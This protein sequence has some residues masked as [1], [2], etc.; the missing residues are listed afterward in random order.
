MEFIE[1]ITPRSY[2]SLGWS[3][4]E[5]KVLTAKV[6]NEILDRYVKI[7]NDMVA[8]WGRRLHTAN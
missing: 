1:G 6:K 7:Y 2:A 4:R 3:G 5:I 8:V